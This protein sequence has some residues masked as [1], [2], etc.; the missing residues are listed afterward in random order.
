MFAD[1][2]R[3]NLSLKLIERSDA[4]QTSVTTK[5][6]WDIAIRIFHWSLVLFFTTSYLTGEEDSLIHIY[7]GYAVGCLL[8]FR[9]VWGFIGS[10]HARFKDFVY[11]PRQ[12]VKYARGMLKGNVSHTD[13]H[14]P[15]GGLMVIALL[16]CLTLT[17]LSGL[18]VYG[19]E[20]HGPL[21]QTEAGWLVSNAKASN[22]EVISGMTKEN[23]ESAEHFWEEI[24]E[25]FANFTLFL[26]VLHI[27]GVIISSRLEKQNLVRAMITGKKPVP[28]SE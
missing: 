4:M 2:E 5:P 9:L 22:P 18:K 20:G 14:N 24:H 27:S 19:L 17:T 21:A 6:V 1:E 13:G 11:A 25:F 7:S 23:N 3:L 10:K 12:V 28:A 26:I 15:L 8:I 16:A